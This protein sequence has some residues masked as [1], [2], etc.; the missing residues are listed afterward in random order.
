MKAHIETFGC[1]MNFSDTEI[2]SSL[3]KDNGYEMTDSPENADLI[4]LNTCSVRDNAER[5]IHE[6]II[7]LKQY[8]RSNKKLLVGILGCMA[9]R[10]RYKLLEEKEIVNLVVGPDEY[11]KLPEI[12]EAAANGDKGIAV[13]LSRVETYDDIEPLREEGISAF[14]SIMR[15]CNNFCS[16]CVVPYTR[17]RERSRAKNGIVGEVLKLRDRGIKEITLLGQNVNSYKD[18]DSGADFPDLLE[19]L[20]DLAPEMRFRFT[21]SHPKDIS[22]KL[23][24]TIARKANICNHLHLPAQ[25][26]S[27]EM[28]KQMNRGYTVE[29]YV[30][31]IEKLRELIPDIALST[32]II[33][34]YPGESLEDHKATLELMKTV[35][36]DGA[37]MFKYSPREGTKAYKIEDNIPED[38][39]IR[40]LNEIIALQQEISRDK[41]QDE[42]GKEYEVLVEGVSKRDDKEWKGRN[43][44][45]KVVIFPVPESM[46]IKEG[47]IVTTRIISAG[48][49]T[50]RGELIK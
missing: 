47:D 4:L 27:N 10:L 16:Y 22:L 40:R 28:L 50:M 24:Q 29:E 37:F 3:L 14:I 7:H 19:E 2:V 38:E 44:G 21:T 20:A 31:K 41:N 11:R 6:R 17:G 45:N 34:A 9:E 30:S 13:K 49:A 15:G 8:S 33:A 39:K 26:G 12:I 35:R 25:S 48:A 5:K 36:Y 1:Q 43:G 23:M 18:L 46:N 42:I 32:D